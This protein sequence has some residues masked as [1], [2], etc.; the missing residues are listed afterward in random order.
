MSQL[1]QHHVADEY[2]TY[3]ITFS[4][5]ILIQLGLLINTFTEPT[6]NE[7]NNSE[8]INLLKD[9]SKDI[10]YPFII[11]SII[12]L[13]IMQTILHFFSTDG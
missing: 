10:I 2:Y 5:L 9:I 11:S 8:N 12:I 6:K 4:L 7:N 3:S 1:N 13:A